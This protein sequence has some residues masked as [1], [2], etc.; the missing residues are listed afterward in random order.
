MHIVAY[1]DFFI[2]LIRIF[3]RS[4]DRTVALQRLQ[5]AGVVLTTSE[6]IIFDLMRDAT[7]PKFREISGLVKQHN[8]NDPNEFA[9]ST[10]L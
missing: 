10:T 8:D 4:Y 6:S 7:H 5:E 3:F 1:V 2:L 9:K